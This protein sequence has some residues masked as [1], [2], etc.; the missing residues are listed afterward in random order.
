MPH[1]DET[2]PKPIVLMIDDDRELCALLQEYCA[3]EGL[4]LRLAHSGEEGLPLALSDTHQLVVLDVMMPGM[5]GIEVLRR[6][7]AHS[8]IPVLM[9]TAMGDDTDRILGLEL[10]ADDYVPKPCTP[11]ELVARVRAILRRTV[12]AT[13]SAPEVLTAGDLRMWPHKRMATVKDHPVTLTG[14]EFC[15]LAI[16]LRQAGQA[17][18]RE[19]LYEEGLGRSLSRYDRSLDVH[20]SNIR[21]KLGPLDDGRSRI[22]T[23]RGRGY[24][25]VTV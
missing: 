13:E 8:F 15:I 25:L 1:T 4:D 7:R 11:R 10:G 22:Q 14:A 6:I 5:S 3:L 9:L 19:T 21:H 18:S 16:L 17:V 2:A 23:L 20:L 12:A 24:Q